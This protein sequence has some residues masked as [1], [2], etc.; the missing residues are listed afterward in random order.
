M[1]NRSPDAQSVGT[2]N[3]NHQVF[4]SIN[5]FIWGGERERDKMGVKKKK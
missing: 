5:L 2:R 3:C 4:G 1:Q